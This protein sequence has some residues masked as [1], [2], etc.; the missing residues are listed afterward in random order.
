MKYDQGVVVSNYEVG[1]VM[2]LG[3]V[4]FPGTASLNIPVLI[5]EVGGGIPKIY[6]PIPIH[7]D[8]G[9]IIIDEAR[10]MCA[11]YQKSNYISVPGHLDLGY[12]PCGG[13]VLVMFVGG[14]VT[15]PLVVDVP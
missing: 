14:D 15:K 5:G 13:Q 4:T 8:G 12:V 11:P 2:D 3:G 9:C 10:A 1:I 6:P 7:C